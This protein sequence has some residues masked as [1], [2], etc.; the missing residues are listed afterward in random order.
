MV[1]MVVGIE[2]DVPPPIITSFVFGAMVGIVDGDGGELG[3]DQSRT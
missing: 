1:H 3:R 2:L